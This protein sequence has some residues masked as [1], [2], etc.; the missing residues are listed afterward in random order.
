MKFKNKHKAPEVP[1]PL[2]TEKVLTEAHLK[3]HQT[4]LQTQLMEAQTKVVMLQGAIQMVDLQL[5][6]M[7]PQE[8]EDKTKNGA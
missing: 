1:L 7:N 5:K 8:T 6:E 4:N 2:S 3:D